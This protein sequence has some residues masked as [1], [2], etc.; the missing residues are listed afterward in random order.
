MKNPFAEQKIKHSK[1]KLHSKIQKTNT[2]KKI[3]L[4]LKDI[5]CLQRL[6]VVAVMVVKGGGGIFVLFS[7]SSI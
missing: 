3:V 2:M 6:L 1:T 7:N 4:V 5:S